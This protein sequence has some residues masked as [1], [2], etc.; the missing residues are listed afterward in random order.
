M[1]KSAI[2]AVLSALEAGSLTPLAEDV[3]SAM[4]LVHPTVPDVL[5]RFY[6]GDFAPADLAPVVLDRAEAEDP[7]RAQV[8]ALA[9]QAH[10]LATSMSPG[11]ESVAIVGGLTDRPSYARLLSEALTRQLSGLPVATSPRSP[12]EG[13][14]QW[15]E[16]ERKR[17]SH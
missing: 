2:K 3:M 10:R 9:A 16:E 7:A 11:P 1:G 14:L 17:L 5:D 12:A 4:G 8:Q 13:A 6:G 15:A